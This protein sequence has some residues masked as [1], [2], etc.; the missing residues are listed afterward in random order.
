MA[1]EQIIEDERHGVGALVAEIKK[2]GKGEIKMTVGKVTSISPLK[3][4]LND[5]PDLL[6]KNDIMMLAHVSPTVNSKIT[7]MSVDRGINWVAIGK[8][9]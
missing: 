7:L 2:M 6:D 1:Y 9:V 4:K 3:V 8:V 5:L